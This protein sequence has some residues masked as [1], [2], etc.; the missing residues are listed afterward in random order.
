MPPTPRP[1]PTEAVQ[2]ATPPVRTQ[3]PPTKVVQPAPP[4]R[5]QPPRPEPERVVAPAKRPPASD[6]HLR[7]RLNLMAIPAAEVFMSGR[8]IGRTPIVE[9]SLR[10]G[11]YRLVVRTLD[12]RQSRT[13][14]VRIEANESTRQSV[15]F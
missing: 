8:S 15:R 14:N 3:P 5:A 9:L 13:V 7:G 2:S 10:P 1:P 11:N 6:R 4:V 12:G